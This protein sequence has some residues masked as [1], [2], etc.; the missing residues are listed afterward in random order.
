M[1]AAVA[2]LS[3]A[4][5]EGMSSRCALVVMVWASLLLVPVTPAQ[6]QP[7]L[8]RV[9]PNGPGG[10]PMTFNQQWPQ[11]IGNLARVM[12]VPM[13]IESTPAGSVPAVAVPLS[14]LTLREALDT[15]ARAARYEWR[16]MDGV[17]VLRP[18]GAWDEP[19]HPLDLLMEEVRL[20]DA[21]AQQALAVA[22]VALG[23]SEGPR[24]PERRR[25]TLGFPGGRLIDFLNGV[26]REHG[27]LVWSFAFT[28]TMVAPWRVSLSLLS[29]SSGF[30]CGAPGTP[31]DH[32]VDLQLVADKRAVLAGPVDDVLD[33]PVGADVH[34]RPL[35]LSGVLGSAVR[36]LATA[37]KVPMGL[38]LVPGA[39]KIIRRAVT[40]TGVPL[41]QV[42]D[43]LL[44]TDP[45]YEWR[46][47]DGVVVV[48][49]RA[50][51]DDPAHALSVMA[52]S[53]R[54]L[55][56][57]IDRLVRA[58]LR[59]LG[60]AQPSQDFPDSRLVWL[61]LPPVPA[62]DL[63]CAL[64]RAHGDLVWVFDDLEPE[65]QK[66]TGLRHRL[67]LMAPSGGSG[68]PVR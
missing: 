5:D 61:D 3:L 65:D 22:C 31:P 68:T 35:L 42:L 6:A 36:D 50:S 53:V 44:T 63:L 40:A 28:P 14:G 39:P 24:M 48:R 66:I 34:G 43:G 37:A 51:W 2:G 56:E 29:G 12:G 49:P 47:L 30:G 27:A 11:Q 25:F 62:V 64:A 46:Y 9:V 26:V 60:A 45:R 33:R 59:A 20:E 1:Q 10:R 19:S 41:R 57:P 55:D 54:L 4:P 21:V 18:R 52:E 16:V 23:A 15:L 32:P 8:D 17:I 7:R 67:W 38:E 13:G 58:T